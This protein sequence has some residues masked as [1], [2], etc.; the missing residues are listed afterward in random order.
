MSSV[1]K[2]IESGYPEGIGPSPG[3]AGAGI[4]LTV[5][6]KDKDGNILSEEC[7]DGDLY[8]KIGACFSATGSGL[9]LHSFAES[10]KPLNLSGDTWVLSGENIFY[11]DLPI[12]SG[13]TYGNWQNQA[14]VRVGSSA[15]APDVNQFDV[16]NYITEVIPTAPSLTN[17]GNTVKL[18]FTATIPVTNETTFAE[19]ALKI[20]DPMTTNGNYSASRGTISRR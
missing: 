15:V 3:V 9:R 12:D 20:R 2:P 17:A 6:V 13:Y 4:T 10:Y 18:I 8:L 1:C 14:R 11:A 19:T 7:K 5:T 16:L